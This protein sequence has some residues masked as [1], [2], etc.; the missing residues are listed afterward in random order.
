MP[1]VAVVT[2]IGVGILVVVLAGYLIRVA[3]ILWQVV[4]QLEVIIDGVVAVGEEAAPIG[5]VANAINA[6]LDAGRRTLEAAVARLGEE[7]ALSQE[8][9]P[10][11]GQSSDKEG[12]GIRW[13]SSSFRQ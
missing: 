11:T 4:R 5:Q 12:T 9:Q 8:P 13:Q 6:D 1:A 7:Q 3:F 2:L 10:T